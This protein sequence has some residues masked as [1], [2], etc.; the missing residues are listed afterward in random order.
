LVVEVVVVAMMAMMTMMTRGQA[1]RR[2]IR[3]RMCLRI[4]SRV[5]I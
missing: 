3:P 4:H 1:I 5:Q 2:R